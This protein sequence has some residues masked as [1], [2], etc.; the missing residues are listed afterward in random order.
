MDKE[1]TELLDK[2]RGRSL[3]AD[4]MEE[5]RIALAVANGSLSDSRITVDT[6]RA[7]ITVIAAAHKDKE[8]A[9]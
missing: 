3:S 1:L 4:E 5:H 9:S 2:S 8:Y 7:G 6:M